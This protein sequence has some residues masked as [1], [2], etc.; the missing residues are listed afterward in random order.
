MWRPGCFS[1]RRAPFARQAGRRA[2]RPAGR[3]A[4]HLVDEATPAQR[5][6]NVFRNLGADL[7]RALQELWRHG[8]GRHPDLCR[9]RARLPAAPHT[10]QAINVQAMSKYLYAGCPAS[11]QN[12]GLASHESQHCL[13]LVPP[14][15]PSLTC[16]CAAPLPP[17]PPFQGPAAPCAQTAP[18]GS[19]C[20]PPPCPA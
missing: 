4:A 8:A 17:S 1:V 18:A 9:R 20:A 15:Q 7:R 5:S 12:A 14:F 3:Q 13:P 16:I 6:H 19:C 11:G 2:G 10:R